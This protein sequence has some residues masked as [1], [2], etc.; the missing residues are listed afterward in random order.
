[1]IIT[2]LVQKLKSHLIIIISIQ[3]WNLNYRL[4]LKFRKNIY[5]YD[6]LLCDTKEVTLNVSLIKWFD[7]INT[8]VILTQ[9]SML[10]PPLWGKELYSCLE[11]WANPLVDL[12]GD[13]WYLTRLSTH[14]FNVRPTLIYYIVLRRN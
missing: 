14:A 13:L 9:N 2:T 11:R 6:I 8:W 10:L 12:V 1:M 7:I 4:S 5:F 3:K